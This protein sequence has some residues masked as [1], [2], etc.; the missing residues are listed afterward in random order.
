MTG[1]VLVSSTE[2]MESRNIRKGLLAAI[3][4]GLIWGSQLVPLKVG[5][6]LTADFFFPVCLGIFLTGILIAAIKRMKFKYEAVGFS[7]ASGVI[8]NI[9]NLLSLISLSLIGLSK[10]GPISQTASLVAVGWGL[11]ILKRYPGADRKPRF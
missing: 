11:F 4:A 2:N 1:V 6:V 7:L 10:A 3:S 8:W 9:G 5:N